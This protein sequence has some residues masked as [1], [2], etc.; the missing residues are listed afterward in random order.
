MRAIGFTLG[1]MALASVA[2]AQ[3]PAVNAGGVVNNGGYST[4]GV[5]PGSIVAIFGTSLASKLAIGD[6]IPLSNTLDTVT[7]VKFNDTEAGL[8]FVSST[9][10][11]AQLPYE[12]LAA[13][14]TSA[15][16][17][18]VVT[19]NAGSSA[20]QTVNVLPAVPGIF[21]VN[22][23]GTGQAIATDNADS[24]FAAAA[25]SITGANAHPFAMS[26]Q[27]ENGHALVIWC[28]GLGAVSPSIADSANSVN[29]DGSI[30]L[31]KTTF[32]PVVTVGGVP[33]QVIFSGLAPG[34]VGEYQVDVLL[35]SGTP[36]GD[37]VPLV[38]EV[39]GVTSNQVSVAVS[40]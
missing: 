27:G 3:A 9:Q 1:I 35:G 12:A 20:A 39:N 33:A 7:S 11:A 6:T 34:F 15:T 24:A 36:T 17:N 18:I 19:T 8:Y 22:Q 2:H 10:L 13:N 25:G 37:S 14:A 38:I 21:S 16:V 23:R 28:T 40:N 26:T 5:A 31:R 32:T 4:Q 29:P 30:T